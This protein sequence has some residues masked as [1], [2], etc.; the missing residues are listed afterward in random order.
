MQDWSHGHCSTSLGCGWISLRAVLC[1]SAAFVTLASCFSVQLR[2]QTTG[3]PPQE[4]IRTDRLDI[5][6]PINQPP[7]A[8]AQLR[9]KH[10]H[11]NQY[12]FDAANALRQHQIADEATKLLILARDVNAQLE[13]LGGEPLPDKLMREIEVIER[14][15]HDV[16]QKMILTVGPS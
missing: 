10:R 9:S 6:S 13:R 11:A 4:G 7:D 8:N 5:P 16:Q 15:A 3:T 14:F 2:A 12:N 1:S